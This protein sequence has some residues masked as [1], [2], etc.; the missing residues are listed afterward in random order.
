MTD[1]EWDPTLF[2][3]SA[4]HYADGRMAYP[5]EVAEAIGAELGLDGTGRLLDVG[6]GPGSLTL[7]LAPRFAEAVGVDADADMLAEARRR[8]EAAG[9]SN[10]TWRHLRAEEL[11]AGLGS[12][13]TAVFAQSFHWM[14][15]S[16]VAQKVR[17][18]LEPG[19]VWVHVSASTHRGW[20]VDETLP[21]PRPP[22]EDVDALV[23]A[24]LGPVRRAGQGFLA[25]GT[26]GG[27][28]AVMREAG[29][30][31]PVRIT[32]DTGSVVERSAEA[33]VSAVFSL[34]YAA[35]HL[36]GDRLD[37]FAAD[38]RALLGKASPTGRFAERL[39]PIEAAL[40]RP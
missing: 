40:W 22:W 26:A 33:I 8:A 4:A 1:W 2:S 16:L 37:E 11:P 10:V 35:P 12:F 17:D 36:F 3:G 14:D 24:Y 38:L 31:G 25:G 7:S 39:S 32:V 18:M 23:A 29:Y 6:C 34:S 15:R 13:R 19:G 5:A 27:E 30:R 20:I 9:V 21:L 28:E